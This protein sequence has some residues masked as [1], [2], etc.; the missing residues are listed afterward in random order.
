MNRKGY[1]VIGWITWQIASRVAK[2][3][4][5]QNKLKLGAAASVLLVLVA[6][7]VAAWASGDDDS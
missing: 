6:G 7:L 3:K 4:M 2:R 1:T 5:S